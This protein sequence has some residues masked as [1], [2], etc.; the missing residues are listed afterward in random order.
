MMIGDWRSSTFYITTCWIED[1]ACGWWYNF[2]L[3]T[4]TTVIVDIEWGWGCI[5]LCLILVMLVHQLRSPFFSGVGLCCTLLEGLRWIA[6]KLEKERTT[7]TRQWPT[8]IWLVYLCKVDRWWLLLVG[9]FFL[10]KVWACMEM[11]MFMW[12]SCWWS[13][14]ILSSLMIALFCALSAALGMHSNLNSKTSA[15]CREREREAQVEWGHSASS[16][17][18]QFEVKWLMSHLLHVITV[19]KSS[20]IS[21]SYVNRFSSQ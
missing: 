15:V 12:T 1:G 14:L 11:F 6:A 19:S 16:C 9:A 18:I 5:R 8:W 21:N 10:D 17:K 4:T 7:K 2:L 13:G 20:Y 3:V